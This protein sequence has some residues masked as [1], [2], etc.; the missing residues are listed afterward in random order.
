MRERG[1][2]GVIATTLMAVSTFQVLYGGDARMYALLQLLGVA[3]AIITEQWLRAP[4]RWH[5]WA[6]GAVL[7]VALFDHVSGALLGAGLLAVAGLRRDRDAWRWRFVV[8][9]A[10]LVWLVVWGPVMLDQLGGQWAS[11]IPRTTPLGFAQTVSRQI[12]LAEAVAPFVLAAVIGGGVVLCR[13]DRVLGRLWLALGVLPFALAAVIGVFA[14]FLFDRTLTLAS[15]AP[16]LALAFLLDAARRRWRMAGTAIALTVVLIVT[17][18]SCTF[19]LDKRWDYDLSVERLE[20][21]ARP[22]DVIAVRPARY[23]I[24]VDWRIGVRG[25]RAT[26]HVRVP[27][28][29]DADTLLRERWPSDDRTACGCSRRSGA[30]P[31]SRA[32]RGARRGGPTTSPRSSASATTRPSTLR[33]EHP[34]DR[35]TRPGTLV[36]VADTITI[37]GAREHNLRNVDLELPRDKLIVFT[38]I[39]GSGKSSL[40]FDTIY[41]EGQRRYVESLSAYARQFLGQMDK[42]DVDFIEGLSPAISIDQKSGSKN[43]RS[44]VGTITEIYDYLRLLYARIGIAHCPECGRVITRQTPQQI[45]DRVLQLPEGTR[46]QVLAPVVRG[47]KGEY[48]GMLKELVVAGVH[49]RAGRRRARRPRRQR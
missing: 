20:Q 12:T 32:T 3:A 8:T 27:D 5:A 47:R 22:G 36:P 28:L 23:G 48:E 15:W 13:R 1:W 2:L 43:P 4:A 24:L 38:G 39:S 6:I 19:F 41:A 44:T 10:G 34:F 21:V 7:L 17:T 40:A 33:T 45:V 46:F 37:R 11:W 9:G 18:A 16:L 49:A 42:P 29:G 14:S 30:G 35:S 26:R 31:T 25:D